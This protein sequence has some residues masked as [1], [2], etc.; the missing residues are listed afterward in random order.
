MCHAHLQYSSQESLYCVVVRYA[1]PRV[2]CVVLEYLAPSASL[3]GSTHSFLY[4]MLSSSWIMILIQTKIS[5]K[6]GQVVSTKE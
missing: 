2:I 6:L 5:S 3:L 4:D 1:N